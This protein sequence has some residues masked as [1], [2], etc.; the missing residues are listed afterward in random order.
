MISGCL[1][2]CAQR[3]TQVLHKYLLNEDI[4]APPWSGMAKA[5][6]CSEQDN[7]QEIL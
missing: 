3:L 7:G 4:P 2:I 5:Q 6:L 1:V